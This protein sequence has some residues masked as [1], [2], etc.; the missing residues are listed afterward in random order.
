MESL[1]MVESKLTLQLTDMGNADRFAATIQ[2]NV[3]HSP[4]RGWM[5]WDGCRWAPDSADMVYEMA[6]NCVK[7]IVVEAEVEGVTREQAAEIVKHA[8]RSQSRQSLE[9]MLA[10]TARHPAISISDDQLD[11][12]PWML[13][14]ANGVVDL[15]QG[16][17]ATHDRSRMNS[18]CCLPAYKVDGNRTQWLNFVQTVFD[19][20]PGLVRWVQK[21]VGYTLTGST[22]EQ[23]LFF[24]HGSG[25]NGKSTFVET[26]SAVLG[27]YACHTH[28]ETFMARSV[29]SIRNDLARLVGRRMVVATEVPAGKRLD[30]VGVKS[31]T[32]EERIIARYLHKEF[33]EFSPAFKIWLSGNHKPAIVGTDFAIW[34]RIRVIPFTVTIAPDKADKNLRAKLLQEAEGILAWAVEGCQLWQLE[35]LDDVPDEITQSTQRYR[36]EQDSIGWFV[37]EVC[38]VAK[39][40]QITAVEL[41]EAYRG[42]ADTNKEEVMSRNEFWIRLQERVPTVHRY[43][44]EREW[45]YTGLTLQKPVPLGAVEETE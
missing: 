22:R 12:D 40:L 20:R 26:L 6:L 19:N 2:G 14:V 44:V 10:M 16:K 7:R 24:L 45:I 42:W 1:P 21:A 30:E 31:M 11:S 13:A 28:S 41:Y 23:C 39:G 4:I 15:R 29:G 35:G 43:R 33:F 3:L 27:D 25:L 8:V 18:Y 17:L 32:G 36:E 37:Q 38:A 5:L 34:R 9:A